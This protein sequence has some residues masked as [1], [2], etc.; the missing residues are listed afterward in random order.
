MDENEMA[1]DSDFNCCHL[2]FPIVNGQRS[3]Y[4]CTLYVYSACPF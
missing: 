1:D 2:Q 3:I 4:K